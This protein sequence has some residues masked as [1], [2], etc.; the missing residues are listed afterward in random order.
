MKKHRLLLLGLGVV[1][2]AALAATGCFI[3]SAQVFAHFDLPNPFTIQSTESPFERVAVDL[4]TVTEYTDNKDK[5]KGL[6]DVAIIG[7]FTN[8]LGPAGGVEVWIT[9]GETN[10]DTVE[11]ITTN[12]TKLWGPGSIGATGAVND[13]TWDESAKLFKAAGKTILIN[14]VKGDGQFTVYIIGTAGEY[15]IRVDKGG[16]ILVLDAGV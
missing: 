8:V 11:G 4:N 14:E 12:A 2:L 6:A 7:K 13:I 5:L 1:A 3:T 10:Y 16:I 9:A 15:H